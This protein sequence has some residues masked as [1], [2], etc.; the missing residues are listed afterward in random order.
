MIRDSY[1]Y[2]E[3]SREMALD[4]MLLAGNVRKKYGDWNAISCAGN[5]AEIARIK[6]YGIYHSVFGSS[7]GKI[8]NI[9]K[10]RLLVAQLTPAVAIVPRMFLS[11]DVI[12]ESVSALTETLIQIEGLVSEPIAF[13]RTMQN[14]T[15]R[16]QLCV[17]PIGFE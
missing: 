15:K 8:L 12:P 7:P 16:L 6:K 11:P 4:A 2:R 1:S 10:L 5:P 17:P 9:A 13:R 3:R 14:Q